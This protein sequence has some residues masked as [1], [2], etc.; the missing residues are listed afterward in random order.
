MAEKPENQESKFDP[1]LASM[2]SEELL[3]K[4]STSLSGITDE[5][6]RKR[7]KKYGFNEPAKAKEHH[8]LVRFILSFNNPLVIILMVVGTI[9]FLMDQKISAL[10]TYG[11]AILSVII[12]FFQELKAGVEAKKLSELVSTTSAVIRHGKEHEVN[13]RYLVPGD[14]V[15][16][17]A[18]DLIPADI[19]ILSSK[20]LFVN[21]ASLTGE[22]F[23]AEKSSEPPD[24]AKGGSLLEFRNIA[25][26]GTNVAS[27]T[28]QAL[29]LKTG[30][31]TQ[32]GELAARVS[33]QVPETAFDKGIKNF[34]ILM[35]KLIL[36]LVIAI[37]TIN[38]ILK[39][40]MIEALLFSL[41]VAVGLAPE[42]LPMMIAVNLSSGA[43][44][45]SKKKVIVKRL[46]S[47]QNF[48]AMDILCTDKTGTLTLDE[49]ILERHFDLGGKDNDDV[50]LQAYLNSYFQTGL[51]NLLDKAIL[52]HRHLPI[53]NFRKIDEIPFDFTRKMMSVVV[54]EKGRHVLISKGALEEIIQRCHSY[55]LDGKVVHAPGNIP[56]KFKEEADSYRN[57][58]FRVLAVAYKNFPLKKTH[59][60]KE[61][62]AE[63]TLKG[64]MI[65]LDPPKPTAKKAIESVK[66]LGISF[67][68]LTGDGEAITRKVCGDV[69]IDVSGSIITG[70][71][72]DKLSEE[73][74]GKAAEEN[75]VF[76]RLAPLQKERIII[77]LKKRGHIVGYLG[78]GI[79]DA[80]SLKTSD[81]GVSVANA[82]D[83]AKETA[84]IILLRKSLGVLAEGVV[85]GRRTYANIL[86]YLKMGASSNFGNMFSVT[87]ASLFLPFLPMAPIQILLNNFMYDFS[88]ATIPTDGVD[89]EYLRK[90]TPWNIG[91][92]KKMMLFFG[93]ISSL[94]DFICFGAL[95]F[96]GASVTLFHTVWFL[97]S[98]ATQT[99]VIHVI[100]TSKI[101]FIQSRASNLLLFSSIGI[102]LLGVAL[103]LSPFAPMFGFENP[104]IGFLAITAA[105]VVAYLVLVQL[106]K[107]W[108]IK[109]YGYE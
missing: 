20:D 15:A 77:A 89:E 108:F 55:E 109:R 75:S 38:A 72:L 28:A 93:P 35:L 16:L 53:K 26:M 37:F 74:L 68:V 12:S 52:K 47:I 97:E 25:F 19:R 79:N 104:P 51:K 41:A 2:P 66:N 92:I 86:K 50:L 67:K 103:T 39:G 43:I 30:S 10:L 59:Y 21:Q 100:R 99:L 49:V 91:Y 27:G 78:D 64:Y 95:L 71:V 107:M 9:S 3:K 105:I 18:G 88:Q 98:L 11:M 24:P 1:A 81:V 6:A 63:L 56:A 36:I 62:E 14:I 13:I 58:G 40:N 42:M 7:Q 101:P 32:F 46:S 34:V 4:F 17:S 85:E 33:G 94:F 73:E 106:L 102:V 61:D 22:S 82:A 84:D 60:T 80:P 90:P 8:I 29:V 54:E 57:Q 96:L 87:G 31:S 83:I 44:R 48:G 69:G 23:P 45:M 76:A 65:F 5:E 70:D